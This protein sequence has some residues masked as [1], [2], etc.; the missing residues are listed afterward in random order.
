VCNVGYEVV[1]LVFEKYFVISERIA[2]SGLINDVALLQLEGFR[3][4]SRSEMLAFVFGVLVV[5]V[6]FGDSH[7]TSWVGNLDSIFGLT[8]WQALDVVY[9]LASIAVF[10]LYGWVKGGKLRVN[11]ITALLFASFV[12]VLALVNIDDLAIALN[13][14]STKSVVYWTI[15]MWVYPVYSFFAFFLF[16][17]MNQSRTTSETH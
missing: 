14:P 17:K 1:V 5:L 8:L 6:T 2:A 10:L 16:G 12:A 3:M 9:P 15:M 13:F 4:N 11:V 7:L